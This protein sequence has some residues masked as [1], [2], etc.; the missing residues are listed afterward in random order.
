M[1]DTLPA[2]AGANP[3]SV[4]LSD[5]ERL[6]DLDVE[7]LERLFDMHRT[8]EADRAEREFAAAMTAVQTELPRVPKLGWNPQ[9]RSF[10]AKAEDI[11]T[12]LNKLIVH[13]GFST[14]FSEQE[15]TKDE[16]MR[17]RMRLRHVGGHVEDHYW[18]APYDY[19]GMKGNPT[20]TKL[21]GAS[22]ATT[23]AKSRLKRDVFNITTGEVDDDGNM[24]GAPV[25]TIT[26]EQAADYRTLLDDLPEGSKRRHMEH[27]NTRYGGLES[28]PAA[29][30][31]EYV[32]KLQERRASC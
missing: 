18:E 26:E 11:D 28:L 5:P 6:K 3:L 16:H 24:A 1:T 9:T 25:E 17:V 8:L 13:H 14:S 7:K 30:F 29:K 15:S 4:V 27:L 12:A 23:Y 19:M 22:S 32:A 21:H 10:Y 31:G 2:P 20:K